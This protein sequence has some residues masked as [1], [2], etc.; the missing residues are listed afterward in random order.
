[1]SD[2][3]SNTAC[4]KP[5]GDYEKKRQSSHTIRYHVCQMCRRKLS[6]PLTFPLQ[7]QCTRCD[8]MIERTTQYVTSP[9]C[10]EC[11]QDNINY[12]NSYEVRMNR[13][14]VQGDAN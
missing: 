5:L 8:N 1:M 3:C 9:I 6:N 4:R 10:K 11:K 14:K 13:L 7:L 12:N 2:F